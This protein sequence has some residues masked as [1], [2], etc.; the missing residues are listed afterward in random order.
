MIKIAVASEQDKVT[1]HFGHCANFNIFETDKGEILKSESILNPGHKKGFLP[2][3]LRE[4]GVSVIIAGGMGKGAMDL[5]REQEIE[6]II[7]ATG[8]ASEVVNAYLQGNL[9]SSGSVCQ[10]HQHRHHCGEGGNCQ[11]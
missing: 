5:C 1:D 4:K 7:G 11:H 3:Y 2:A 8:Q 10:E 9:E 6:V